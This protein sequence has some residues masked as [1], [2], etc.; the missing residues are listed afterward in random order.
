MGECENVS[1]EQL[2]VQFGAQGDWILSS[3]PPVYQAV[4]QAL[5]GLAGWTAS[6]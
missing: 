5:M 4:D 1:K 6:E 3:W 2:G